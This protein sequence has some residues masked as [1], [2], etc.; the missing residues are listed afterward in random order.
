M[1]VDLRPQSPTFKDWIGVV[2]DGRKTQHAL[3]ARR[4]RA[5]I[6]NARRR[7][8]GFLSDV[9]VPP[10]MNNLAAKPTTPA[11]TKPAS[12]QRMHRA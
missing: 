3:C 6:S 12:G 8:R 1:V 10:V 2:S 9:G 7:D 4:L 11:G 5:W